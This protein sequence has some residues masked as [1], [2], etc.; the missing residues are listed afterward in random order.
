VCG[1][2]WLALRLGVDAGRA[3]ELGLVPFV[4]GDL[5]KVGLA[6]LA[7]PAAWRLVEHSDA[8]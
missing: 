3:M 1:V 7:L 6:A 8:R 5:L 2:S 4:I